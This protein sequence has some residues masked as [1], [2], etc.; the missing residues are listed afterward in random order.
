MLKI[1]SNFTF[2]IPDM[3]KDPITDHTVHVYNSMAI[4]NKKCFSE[5]RYQNYIMPK[6]FIDYLNNYIEILEATE[7]FLNKQIDRLSSAAHKTATANLQIDL[8]RQEVEDTKKQVTD[9][10][11]NCERVMTNIEDCKSI[12]K[13]FLT[14]SINQLNFRHPKDYPKEEGAAR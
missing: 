12:F 6:H 5:Y 7:T 14:R 8:L 11:E 4:Y 10:T 9:A 1:I 3:V 13:R 2:Q